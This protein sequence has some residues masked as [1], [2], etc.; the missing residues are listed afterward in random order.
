MAV[1]G[2]TRYGTETTSRCKPYCSVN[3]V[4]RTLSA[5]EPCVLF[6]SLQP[7]AKSLSVAI[8]SDGGSIYSIGNRY[9]NAPF[10]SPCQNGWNSCTT[11]STRFESNNPIG[12]LCAFGWTLGGTTTSISNEYLMV[13]N[14]KERL[15]SQ[16]RMLQSVID[17]KMSYSN[18][19]EPRVMWTF[20]FLYTGPHPLF[21]PCFFGRKYIAIIEIFWW[22]NGDPYPYGVCFCTHKVVF[23]IFFPHRVRVGVWGGRVRKGLLYASFFWCIQKV[24]FSKE[25]LPS[26]PFNW[27]FFSP[28]P[29]SGF[30]IFTNSIPW[31]P[32]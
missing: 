21:S 2:V 28:F 29:P 1:A 4:R 19:L 11:A 24:F 22:K 6:E 32:V 7:Q 25:C 13:V 15:Y 8:A 18:D 10:L 20:H 31:K 16:K 30:S 27:T 9:A 5:R 14:E 17:G 26:F 3:R 23:N 12:F